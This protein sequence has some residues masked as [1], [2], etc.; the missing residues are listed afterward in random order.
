[1]TNGDAQMDCTELSELDD[2]KLVE[3]LSLA[4]NVMAGL[5]RM[6]LLVSRRL[7]AKI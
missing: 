6:L 7:R 3:L 2:E 5:T 1:M 4:Q